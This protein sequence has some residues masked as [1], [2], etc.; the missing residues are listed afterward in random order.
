MQNRREFLELLAAG[1]A[2]IQIS[3][4]ITP[5]PAIIDLPAPSTTN[6]E[7]AL[8]GPMDYEITGGLNEY[9]RQSIVFGPP[10]Q[11]IISNTNHIQFEIPAGSRVR[12][13]KIYD[14][15]TVVLYGPFEDGGFNFNGCGTLSLYPN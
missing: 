8:F 7:L 11:G 1:T 10:S 6:L 3:D 4:K 15:E 9:E 14:G 5:L 12:S 2:L 13:W